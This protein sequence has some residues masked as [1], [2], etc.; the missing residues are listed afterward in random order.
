MRYLKPIEVSERLSVSVR[1]LRRW[2]KQGKGPSF[3]DV[4]GLPRCKESD[5]IDYIENR[6]PENDSE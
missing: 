3:I 4:E 1:T 6:K 2:R 5:L